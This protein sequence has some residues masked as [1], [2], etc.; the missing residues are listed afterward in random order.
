MLSWEGFIIKGAKKE[1]FC[2]ARVYENIPKAKDPK[3]ARRGQGANEVDE[4]P[5]MKGVKEGDLI[6]VSSENLLPMNSEQ[7]DIK[8]FINA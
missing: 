1:K 7:M 8:R 6:I 4:A 5:S 3:E 2:T